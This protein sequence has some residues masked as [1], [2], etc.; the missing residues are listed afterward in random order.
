MGTIYTVR[1][2]GP[3]HEPEAFQGEIDRRLEE[4]NDQMSTWRPD[5][6]LSR[7]NRYR[8][9]DWFPVSPATATVIAESLRISVATDGAFDVTVGPL[10]NLWQFGPETTAFPPREF[11][12]EEVRALVGYELLQVRLDPPAVRKLHPECYVDLSAIAKGFGVDEIARLCD[13]RGY[14]S[15]LVEIGGEV[16]TLGEK[17][18]GIPW[19]V[20]IEAP[21]IDRRSLQRKLD[22]SG[23]SLAT[24]GDYR[25]FREFDG[26]T[27]SHTIDP[28]TGRPAQHGLAS[29]T[30]LAETCMEADALAT[31][32]MVLGPQEAYDWSVAHDLAAL[33]IIREADGNLVE[34]PTPGFADLFPTESSNLGLIRQGGTAMT[35]LLL[36]MLVFAGAIA[37]MAVGVMMGR[38]R[39]RGTCGGLANFKDS[40]GRPMCD[41]CHEPSPTCAGVEEGEQRSSEEAYSSDRATEEQDRREI[42]DAHADHSS[43]R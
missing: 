20:G 11:K 36:A 41:A 12:L 3:V 32:L 39:L 37:A 8:E 4:I 33:L 18:A 6:E 14:R 5:S 13:A 22:V 10:V 2:V 27:I 16:R 24:S 35:T 34:R 23:R 31:A 26:R 1:I 25:N 17:E 21:R 38:R 42:I 9:S 29:V 40:Q 7:F 28:R 30:V 19:A 15:Y 43:S